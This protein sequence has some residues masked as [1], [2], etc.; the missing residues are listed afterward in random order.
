MI[1][2]A[3]P[4]TGV[5]SGATQKE[6][7]NTKDARAIVEKMSPFVMEQ[8][9]S[10]M[11]NKFGVSRLPRVGPHIAWMAPEAFQTEAGRKEIQKAVQAW[12]GA[13]YVIGN[14]TGRFTPG[15]AEMR[16]GGIISF[17]PRGKLSNAKWM[18]QNRD[19]MESLSQIKELERLT[20]PHYAKLD[21]FAVGDRH[22][23]F[24]PV[25]ASSASCLDCH[26]SAKMGDTL[27]LVLY[28]VEKRSASK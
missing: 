12:S 10:I 18:K 3:V 19:E 13:I 11:T 1:S 2:L 24:K 8:F 28:S 14:K 15:T 27:G 6:D 9:K 23:F 21:E 25:T 26:K 20:K 16:F 4:V 17:S 7:P 22:F 5:L